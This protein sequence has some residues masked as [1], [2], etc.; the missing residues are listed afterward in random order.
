MQ[1]MFTQIFLYKIYTKKSLIPEASSS[2]FPTCLYLAPLK[3]QVKVANVSG[4]LEPY[5][6]EFEDSKIRKFSKK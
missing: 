3:V 6:I 1:Q 5:I 4:S 2:G